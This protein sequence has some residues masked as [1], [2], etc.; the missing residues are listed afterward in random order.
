M[1]NRSN[2]QKPKPTDSRKAAKDRRLQ[3]HDRRKGK[4]STLRAA[5]VVHAT[6]AHV[7]K[8]LGDALREMQRKNPVQVLETTAT[9]AR[10][11]FPFS[12]GNGLGR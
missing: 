4:A 9:R 3:R 1:A 2:H 11:S 12:S 5:K 7:D 8:R 10:F 6:L